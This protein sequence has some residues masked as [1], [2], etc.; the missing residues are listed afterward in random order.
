MLQ[1]DLSLCACYSL[2][3]HHFFSQVQYSDGKL[4]TCCAADI[5]KMKTAAE[6][7]QPVA[8][9]TDK[10]QRDLAGLQDVLEQL[11]YVQCKWKGIRDTKLSKLVSSALQSPNTHIV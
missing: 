6:L 9:A 1:V 7:V 11:A 2:L 4:I 8:Y 3:Y 5:E 10:L